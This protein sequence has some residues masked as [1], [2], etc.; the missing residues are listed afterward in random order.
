M[1]SKSIH[2]RHWVEPLEPRQLLSAGLLDT[3]FG[4]KGFATVSKSGFTFFGDAVAP[5]AQGKIIVAGLAF[6]KTQSFPAVARYNPDGSVDKTFAPDHSGLSISEFTGTEHVSVAIQSDGKIVVACTSKDTA[7]D[8]SPLT[9]AML[10]RFNANGSPDPSF[11]SPFSFVGSYDFDGNNDT[12]ANALAIQ[13]DGKIVFAGDT[14]LDAFVVRLNSDGTLDKSFDGSGVNF[15]DQDDVAAA[16]TLAI[17][18]TGSASTNPNYGK[19]IMAGDAFIFDSNTFR[20]LIA[21]LTTSGHLDSSFHHNGKLASAFLSEDKESFANAIDILP[22]DQ[23]IIAGSVKQDEGDNSDFGII[24]LNSNGSGD[25]TFGPSNGQLAVDF[26]ADDIPTSI[27]TSQTGELIVGGGS[28]SNAALVMIKTSGFIDT[29]F[30]PNGNGKVITTR[31]G[32]HTF[33]SGMAMTLNGKFFAA[34]GDGLNVSRYFDRA[35]STFSISAIVPNASETGPTPAVFTI[36][37]PEV[38]NTTTRVFFQASGTATSPFTLIKKFE[39]YIGITAPPPPGIGQPLFPPNTAYVDIP[40][41]KKSVTFAITPKDDSFVEGNE[42][43]IFTLERDRSYD[44]ASGHGVATATIHDNDVPAGTTLTDTADAYVH[45]GTTAG[46]NFG[47]ATDLEVKHGGS[48]FNR[49]TYIKFDL[50]SVSTINSV[51]LNLFG[52]LS[53]TQNASIATSL[54]SVAD[55]SWSETGIN[56]NNAPAAASSALASATIAGTAL[57]MYQF[58]V[59]AYVKAQLAAGH[60]V[61]SFALKTSASTSSFVQFNSREAGQQRATTGSYLNSHSTHH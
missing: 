61:V 54:F 55:T 25:S 2:A 11:H 30:G 60:K 5:A 59:T 27:I 29:A 9:R 19:I 46:S 23:I 15:F 38:L 42:S 47:T 13:H 51:K 31:P 44:I 52:K 33:A 17:D 32:T 7:T 40:A 57:T 41:G 26:G 18:Y 48:G 20:F 8:G 36:S 22:N 43:V 58:D 50:S 3:T 1:P 35:P 34:G 16:S 4:S 10:L 39:D 6:T 24:R 37:R 12:H 28:D 56:F 53:D 45:D 21:R 49:V 14:G